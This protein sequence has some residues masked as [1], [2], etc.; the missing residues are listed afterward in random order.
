MSKRYA[1]GTTLLLLFVLLEI[2]GY[3]QVTAVYSDYGGYWSTS[4][5]SM[6]TIKPDNSH[7]LLAFTWNGTTYSTGVSDAVL[8]SHGVSYTPC[9]FRAF[10][11]NS[12]P[13]STGSFYFVMLGQKY[14]GIDNGVDNSAAAPFPANPSGSVLAGFLTDGVKGLDLGTGLANIPAGS[15]LRFDLST[16]GLTS[17]AIGDGIPDIFVTEEASP[18]SSSPDYFK[19]VDAGGNT[20]GNVV[21]LTTSSLPQVGSW[22]AD[23]YD[24]NSTQVSGTYINQPRPL[25]FYAADLSAFGIN[26]SNYMN[27]VAFVYQPN[28]TSDPAFIAFNEPSISVSTQLTLTSQPSTYVSSAVLSPVPVIQVRDGLGQAIRQAGI[29]VTASIQSGSGTLGGSLT[30]NTDANGIAN[31]TNLT[32]TGSGTITLAFSSASLN[33]ALSGNITGSV[34]ALSWVSFTAGSSKEGVELK[35]ETANEAGTR[36]FLVLRSADGATWHC[37]DTMPAAGAAAGQENLYHYTDRLPLAGNA[38]YRIMQRDLDGH[39]SYSVIVQTEENAIGASSFFPNPVIDGICYVRLSQRSTVKL[40]S[41]KGKLLKQAVLP[42][43]VQGF[44]VHGLPPG[45]YIITTGKKAFVL[46]IK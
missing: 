37:I 34:L 29:P 12:V 27:A 1:P 43:G 40:F 5:S 21:S 6:S 18:S 41:S 7:N 4:S 20:V 13:N 10:P 36:D 3:G 23:F 14:D 8:T 9:S 15:V 25:A 28:G 11:I 44:D 31:F 26:A 17:G 24:L 30:V 19:F 38:F 42:A 16:N 46:L 22:Q 39:Y 32:I 33:K 2:I 45:S 35:W